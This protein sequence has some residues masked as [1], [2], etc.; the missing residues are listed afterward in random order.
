MVSGLTFKS[1]LCFELIL[2]EWYK[3]GAECHLGPAWD[4]GK[5]SSLRAWV[6]KGRDSWSPQR[7]AE[8]QG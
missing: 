7:E 4:S 2:G 6:E 1:S 8:E 5:Y 3:I